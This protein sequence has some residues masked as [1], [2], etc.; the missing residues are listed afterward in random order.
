MKEPKELPKWVKVCL[1]VLQA[2]CR[3]CGLLSRELSTRKQTDSE[4]VEKPQKENDCGCDETS[5]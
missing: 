4:N 5:V 2:V 3:V 1:K